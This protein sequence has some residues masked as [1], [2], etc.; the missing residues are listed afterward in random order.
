MTN[1]RY[2]KIIRDWLFKAYLKNMRLV[3]SG[4]VEMQKYF[5]SN[6][7]IGFD[8]HKEDG[9]IIAVSNNF[10]YG[11]IITSAETLEE[12]DE[13]IKDAI[14]TSFSI[15]SSYADEAELKRIGAG[16]GEKMAYAAA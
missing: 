15:P 2:R 7:S 13:K 1:M 16:N 14:L 5:R 6:G 10:R 11:S 8:N 12:L 9:I 3:P 4:L